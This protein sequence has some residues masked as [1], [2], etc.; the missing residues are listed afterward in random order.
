MKY[1][2][3]QRVRPKIRPSSTRWLCMCVWRISLRRT[4]SAT[5]S[6]ASSFR[7]ISIEQWSE[8]SEKFEIYILSSKSVFLLST[9]LTGSGLGDSC[10][11]VWF[12]TI[13]SLHKGISL[14][15]S[16]C[17]LTWALTLLRSEKKGRHQQEDFQIARAPTAQPCLNAIHTDC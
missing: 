16:T 7:E 12:K 4:K 6:W 9:K 3:R 13:I 1:G 10:K 11:P 2:S 14:W 8:I 5:I 15:S 17:T